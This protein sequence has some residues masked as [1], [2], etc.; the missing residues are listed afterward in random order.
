M[1]FGK[2]RRGVPYL[3]TEMPRVLMPGEPDSTSIQEKEEAL[4]AFRETAE[5]VMGKHHT[6]FLSMFKQ[7]M[8]GV[9]GPGMEKMFGLV[10]PQDAGETSSAQPTGVQPPLRGQPIQPP[11]QS[12]GN[13][14]IQPP[15]Q[16][17][18]SQ[19]I[20]PPLRGMGGQPV[21]PPLQSNGG[22][23]VQQPNP[24]QPTYGDMAFGSAG[25][26]PNSTYKIAPAS[27]RLQRNMYGGGYHEVMDYGAIDALPNPRYG[28]SAGM[29]DDD[30][31]VQKMADLMQNQFGLKPKM[32]GPAYTP[33]FP[34]WYYRV[35]LP[36]RVKP[37][38]EFTKFSGQDE[39]STVEH[40]ARYL[41]QLGEASADEA[42]RVRYFP[43]SLTGPAFQWFTSLP[44]QSV[45]TW[46]E[47]EKKFHAH[48]FS[49]SMEKKLIDLATLKQRHNETPLEFLRRF[50][51]VKGMCFS[52][53]LPDDQLADMAVVGMLPAVREKLFGMEFDNLGQL[54]QKLSLMS[55][56]AY[57]FKKDTRFAK[58]HDI[59]D[60]YNQFLEKADQVEDYDDD[61]EVAAAEIMWGKEPLTV[62][63]RWIKQTKGTYDFDVTKA[64][65]LFEFLVK[66]GRIKLPEGRSMLRHDGVKEKRYCGFHDRN[67]HSINDCRVFRMRIQRAIQEGHLKFDN[68]MKLDGHPFPQNMVGFSVNMVTPEE[69]GK[70]KVLTSA[71][72][73][74]DGSADP[75]RQVTVDQVRMEAPGILKSQI[76]VGESSGSKPRVTTRILLN[77]WQRQQEK[78][79]YQKRRYEE[80]RRRF[81][82]EARREELEEYAREQEH[83]HWGCA[84]FR[85]CWNEGLKLPTLKNCPEC[86]D[87]YFEY[88]QETVNRRSVHERIGRIHPNDDRHQKI[89]VIDHPRKRQA[90]QRWA[91]Q[92]EEEHEY[93]WQEGQWCPPGLRKSQKR[94]VQRLRN[95]E[96]KQA[97]I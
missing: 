30:V 65:K 92:E 57:G 15:P 7:M 61:Q 78:E 72:A 1:S 58:H 83:A 11:P 68:K 23:P 88:R 70:V 95:R 34:E 76:E 96:V 87:K 20:Q 10:S 47:L 84:F 41:M 51:E 54:S 17:I 82:E 21:Q 49:G 62:N 45:G 13:Q 2:N 63:Q 53:T 24:Y 48:Y 16:S 9:F 79:R 42:F 36:P 26:P 6:A 44:P 89:E 91:D 37:P 55:N 59:V 67:S 71:R 73:K 27:N 40:I 31:L 74:Q 77:K 64:D 32:Q 81:K 39:T 14:P 3:K 12:A 86:S 38:T 25:V 60:I 90:S 35:I 94:R 19:P 18:G 29:Q 80:E 22:Q 85:H 66:E 52:L 5:A 43:L 93:I 75:A 28:T 46:R 97:G 8:I 56:Q 4:D 50:R 69:K 33:P